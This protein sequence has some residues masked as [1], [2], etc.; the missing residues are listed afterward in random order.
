[1]NLQQFQT[2][3]K[4]EKAVVVDFHAHWCGPCKAIAPFFEKLAER[5]S[6][7]VHLVKID[8]DE[9]GDIAE[10]YNVTGMPTFIAFFTGTEIARMTGA[11][12]ED[13]ARLVATIGSH[14]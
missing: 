14:P 7:H 12:K 13:L 2:L 11:N 4:T 8:V 3:L 1:M 5:V 6:D 9:S 10:F